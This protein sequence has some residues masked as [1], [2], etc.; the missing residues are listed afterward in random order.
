MVWSVFFAAGLRNYICHGSTPA[1]SSHLNNTLYTSTPANSSPLLSSGLGSSSS[2]TP[3]LLFFSSFCHVLPTR[4]STA[5]LSNRYVTPL[6][7]GQSHAQVLCGFSCQLPAELLTCP[8]AMHIGKQILSFS[9][10]QHS[11][12]RPNVNDVLGDHLAESIRED[13]E[14][15]VRISATFSRLVIGG[16]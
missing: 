10:I 4:P 5:P 7:N 15:V 11:R 16:K 1:G 12:K 9:S 8:W 2:S 6:L 3:S 13:S 14:D